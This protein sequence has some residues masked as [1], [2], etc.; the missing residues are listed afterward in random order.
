MMLSE[1]FRLLEQARQNMGDARV[2]VE[3]KN[4]RNL[5]APRPRFAAER[6]DV[7]S[8][9]KSVSSRVSSLGSHYRVDGRRSGP[10]DHRS[11]LN[12]QSEAC[13]GFKARISAFRGWQRQ[14]GNTARRRL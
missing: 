8:R 1:R 4:R 9:S 10:V 12:F 6:A 2:S 13:G 7:S 11:A 5:F 3:P 14:T